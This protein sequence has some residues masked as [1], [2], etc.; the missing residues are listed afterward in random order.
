MKWTDV[1]VGDVVMDTHT[2]ECL[3]CIFVDST[4]YHVSWVRL[5]DGSTTEGT[6]TS[7]HRIS[8]Y[9]VYRRGT[10]LYEP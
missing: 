6:L 9:R 3:L 4:V 2:D 8:N 5:E 10:L 7:K 1:T